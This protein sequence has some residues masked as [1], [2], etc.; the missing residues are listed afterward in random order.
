MEL[1]IS[2]ASLVLQLLD[3]LFFVFFYYHTDQ[4]D[5]K[6]S[7]YFPQNTTVCLEYISAEKMAAPINLQ[8]FIFLKF[9]TRYCKG[10]SQMAGLKSEYISG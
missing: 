1:T 2:S 5:R 6:N 10:I 8:E 7:Y 3:L 4:P 9:S